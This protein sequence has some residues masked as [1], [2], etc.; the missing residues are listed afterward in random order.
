MLELDDHEPLAPG[1]AVAAAGHGLTGMR[2]RATL[3]GGTLEAGAVDGSL[4]RPRAAS[5]AG[6]GMTRVRVLIAD[7][8]DL[9]RA[10]LRAVLSSDARIEVVGEAAD[11][12]AAVREAGS[13]CPTSC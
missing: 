6:H 10:G 1:A 13:S 5:D 11:G 8:D 2:E 12:A 3:A 7:D 9:M 4:P